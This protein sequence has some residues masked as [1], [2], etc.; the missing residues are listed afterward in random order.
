MDGLSSLD[1]LDDDGKKSLSAFSITVRSA[2]S[3]SET[4]SLENI[5]NAVRGGIGCLLRCLLG[6]WSNDN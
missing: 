5:E 2:V 6:I 1:S 4:I 3:L